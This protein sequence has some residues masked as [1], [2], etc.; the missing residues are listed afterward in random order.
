[1]HTWQASPARHHW[2]GLCLWISD[3]DVLW[4]WAIHAAIVLRQENCVFGRLPQ[5]NRFAR[6]TDLSDVCLDAFPRHTAVWAL[7]VFSVFCQLDW[8]LKKIRK[9]LVSPGRHF[10][11]SIMHK[12]RL[13]CVARLFKLCRH[14][15][16][17]LKRV[18][19]NTC[20]S[21]S[22]ADCAYWRRPLFSR[23]MCCWNCSQC[24][25]CFRLY[26]AL[27][28]TT[29]SPTC[30]I[31]H[32]NQFRFRPTGPSLQW[33]RWAIGKLIYKKTNW[34]TDLL[35]KVNLSPSRTWAKWLARR[36]R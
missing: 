8:T 28:C 23:S 16:V 35:I 34:N 30:Q 22:A 11:I 19:K 21:N 14:R 13:L 10:L 36:A 32:S 7:L 18:I 2:P 4:L 1:M 17:G 27:L 25:L 26:S 3:V 5:Y 12:T 20:F 31:R 9:P 33:T 29:P 24:R 15:S 6:S